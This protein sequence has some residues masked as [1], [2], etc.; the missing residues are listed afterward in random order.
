VIDSRRLSFVDCHSSIVESRIDCQNPRAKNG[1]I[2][3]APYDE[4][5]D[6]SIGI[7]IVE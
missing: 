2:A 5:P 4:K 6:R 3:K 1:K 7:G